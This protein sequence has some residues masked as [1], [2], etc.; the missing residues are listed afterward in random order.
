MIKKIKELNFK[1]IILTTLA[2]IALLCVFQAAQLTVI[3]V[4]DSINGIQSH[5]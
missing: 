3:R 4:V 2:I 1:K 5:I